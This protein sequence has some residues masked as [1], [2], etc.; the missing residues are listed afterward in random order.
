M[1]SAARVLAIFGLE[2]SY[3][4]SFAC[5]STQ[6]R[7]VVVCGSGHSRRMRDCKW[8]DGC[9]FAFTICDD[10]DNGT[11]ANLKPVYDAMTQAE[12]RTTKTVW[13]SPSVAGD[14]FA[15][16][17]LSDPEY[18]EWVLD[19][20]RQGF[21][22]AWHGT[23]SGG[24]TKGDVMCGLEVFRESLGSSP[25]TYV[26]HAYNVENI[27]WGKERFD[28]RVI[29]QLFSTARGK[30]VAFQGT[31]P[32]S[33]YYWADVC[34]EEITYVRDFT[35]EDIVTTAAD[36]W[37]PYRDA[38]RPFVKAWFSSSN[39]ADVNRFVRLLTPENLDRLE[40]S[41]G[42][43]ILY[44]HIASGFVENGHVRPEV[45]AILAD[46]RKRH[47]WYVPVA[48][49]LDHIVSQRGVHELS[50]GERSRLETR[51]AIEHVGSGIAALYHRLANR[52]SDLQKS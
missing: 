13:S 6:A 4:D 42:A 28:N 41:G 22:I 31:S 19:L 48:E 44:T 18:K 1:E 23:R 46:L 52:Q 45:L 33:E 24:S 16:Q 32:E 47:G 34:L 40:A 21:E 38:R 12:L 15:G 11:L 20:A 50:K 10:T 2:K 3:D 27:Y 17:S 8:P 36:P 51:W 43:C 30:R 29:R 35:F 5:G 7:R 26:N 39:A 14:P 37:M 9:A 49:L 25:R